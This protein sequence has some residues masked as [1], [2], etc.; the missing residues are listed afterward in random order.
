M[1]FSDVHRAVPLFGD[2]QTEHVHSIQFEQFN[3]LSMPPLYPVKLPFTPNDPIAGDKARPAGLCLWR[4]VNEAD[5]LLM[6]NKAAFSRPCA[7]C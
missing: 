1:H 6:R 4:W 2:K 7:L 3:F 5:N